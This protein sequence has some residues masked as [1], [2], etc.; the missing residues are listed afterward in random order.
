VLFPYYLVT[1]DFYNQIQTF[2][3]ALISIEHNTAQK[4]FYNT[5][6]NDQKSARRKF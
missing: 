4:A 3:P 1:Q 5:S 2:A 6:Y